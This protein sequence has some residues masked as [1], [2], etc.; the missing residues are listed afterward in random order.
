MFM[1]LMSLES[2]SGSKPSSASTAARTSLVLPICLN[3][4]RERASPFAAY[5]GGRPADDFELADESMT[6]CPAMPPRLRRHVVGTVHD[7]KAEPLALGP[8]V[9]SEPR[10][11]LRD[12][13]G[14]FGIDRHFPNGR[15]APLPASVARLAGGPAATGTS[16][17]V[18]CRRRRCRALRRAAVARRRR[19]LLVLAC[20][21]RTGP[22]ATPACQATSCPARI[23]RPSASPPGWPG[24]SC[25]SGR[26]PSGCRAG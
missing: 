23:A 26:W 16:A 15:V 1:T 14:P 24:W 4:F 13:P 25:W 20:P 19:V 18:S 9:P 17:L 5:R 7:E 2:T 3:P 12:T 11:P 8:K 6:P 21:H 10:L 22:R